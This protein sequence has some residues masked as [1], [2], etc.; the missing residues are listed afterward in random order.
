[1]TQ[2]FRMIS[3]AVLLVAFAGTQVWA[4]SKVK[5]GSITGTSTAPHAS[6]VL[7]MESSQR[8]ML[9]PR[10]TTTQ[11][12]AISSP[13]TGL[14]V[15]NTTNGCLHQYTGSAWQSLCSSATAVFG[16]T[17]L[18]TGSY[19]VQATDDYV[20]LQI[21]TAGNVLTLPTSGIPTGKRVYVSNTGT[22]N[23]DITP[24]PLNN[25]YTNVGAGISGTLIYLGGTGNGSWDWVSGF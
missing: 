19:T 13:A 21:N 7:E 11:M 16:I 17:A 8:G 4:Q 22:N 25:S 23:I 2:S 3:S 6:A 24:Q 20:K 5:D 18:Q 10:M 12:N 15:Y 9:P 14:L 1:M